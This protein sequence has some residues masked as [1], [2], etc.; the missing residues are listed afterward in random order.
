[1]DESNPK[2]SAP[3]GPYRKPELVQ[4]GDVRELTMNVDAVGKNDGGGG[5]KTKT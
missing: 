3:K 1:M 4:Y 2:Q 5:G